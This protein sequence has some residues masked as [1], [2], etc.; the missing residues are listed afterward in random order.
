MDDRKPKRKGLIHYRVHCNVAS[1]LR[2]NSL[3]QILE[4]IFAKAITKRDIFLL[5]TDA[6]FYNTPKD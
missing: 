1:I 3:L 6:Q 4:I 5:S 2:S